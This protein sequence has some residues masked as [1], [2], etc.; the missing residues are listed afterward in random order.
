MKYLNIVSLV[1]LITGLLMARSLADVGID[2][3]YPACN[4]EIFCRGE[5]LKTVQ[6]SGIFNDSK[7]FVDKPTLKPESKIIRAFKALPHPPQKSDIKSFVDEN[8]GDENSLLKTANLSDWKE[9]PSFLD[10]IKDI[11]Y[12]SFAAN[13]HKKWKDLAKVQDWSGLCPECTSTA[14]NTSGI[15]IIPGGRFRELNYWDTFFILEGLLVSELYQTSKSVIQTLLDLVD[16][17]GFVPNGA[18]S[19]YLNRS[20]PPLLA[21]MIDIYYKATNDSSFAIQSVPALLKEHEFWSRFR[22]VYIPNQGPKTNHTMYR[23]NAKSTSP[24]P[25]SF[26]VDYS[27]AARFSSDTRSRIYS[28]LASG[29]ESG[30]DFSAR[31]LNS[32]NTSTNTTY[33][34][35]NMSVSS[36]IPAD[37]NAIMYK[38][39][40]I[41]A[42][43]AN[44]AA[45]S[46]SNSSQSH[47]FRTISS[48][49]SVDAN[50]TLHSIIDL[51]KN[52]Q[53]GFF[54]DLVFT[55]SS[56][57]RSQFWSP[58]SI[59]PYMYINATNNPQILENQ[60]AAFASI[61]H[62][63]YPSGV[64]SSL[65]NSSLQWDFPSVWAP[66]QYAIVT[67]LLNAAK[68][69]Q[70]SVPN[71][72]TY[73]STTTKSHPLAIKYNKLALSIA[74]KFI[75][76][77][78][79]AW[80]KSF[81]LNSTS[82]S[83]SGLIYEKMDAEKFGVPASSG[84]Y[85]TQTG[86][87]WTNGVVIKL[88]ST[89]GPDLVAPNCD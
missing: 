38:S 52:N 59:W 76:S 32:N 60:R 5:I 73:L 6:L 27:L 58:A 22:S 1:T 57:F 34:L 78:Y 35:T 42:N 53:T 4:S 30:I 61:F 26:S 2:Y 9:H 67:S 3:T 66:H 11:K 48:T 81:A 13:I 33:I 15:F 24:R 16:T 62:L 89:F 69:I 45:N 25:E 20:Q 50:Q 51:M 37:L 79:C 71:S 63:N 82:A 17:Y 28:Q 56:Y 74:S 72:S 70:N 12:K 41:I 83:S 75:A 19:Y 8:F 43:L 64:P 47:G 21:H 31:W 46:I 54:D 80:S 87:G 29:A 14:L 55:R 39:K 7:I 36:I 85:S 10:S 77:I 40:L 88:F 44:L 68:S 18:R 49:F 86:F 84:E 23:Y 65:V